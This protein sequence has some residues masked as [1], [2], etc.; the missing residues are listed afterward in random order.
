MSQ[1]LIVTSSVTAF[2]LIWNRCMPFR[3]MISGELY[4]SMKLLDAKEVLI[5]WLP[6]WWTSLALSFFGTGMVATCSVWAVVNEV[7][8]NP[9]TV[10]ILMGMAAFATSIGGILVPITMA[11]FK[12]RSE[13]RQLAFL[14]SR[15]VTLEDKV[16]QNIK[17]HNKSA[18]RLDDIEARELLDDIENLDAGAQGPVGPI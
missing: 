18:K 5:S 1:V 16:R 15:L 2:F 14:K 11:Y 8:S 13:T 7:N 17:E 10:P 9:T 6:T 3:G 12:D 4:G